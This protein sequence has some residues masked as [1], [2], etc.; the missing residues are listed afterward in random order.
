MITAET[1]TDTTTASRHAAKE[2][3]DVS[4]NACQR[5]WD[6]LMADDA[7]ALCGG[8]KGWEQLRAAYWAMRAEQTRR[9]NAWL[10][11]F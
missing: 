11:H 1:T 6:Q 9:L 3:Y 10:A 5:V 7:F 4:I 8:E 2:A